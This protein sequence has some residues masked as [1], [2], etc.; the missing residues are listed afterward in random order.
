MILNTDND[1]FNFFFN[2]TDFYGFL[3]GTFGK[4]PKGTGIL[5]RSR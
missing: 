5:S 4:N 2:L 3:S 1:F